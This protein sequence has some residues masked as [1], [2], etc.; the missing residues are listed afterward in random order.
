M[1]RP[2][3]GVILMER[4]YIGKSFY[5]NVLKLESHFNGT[6]LYWRVILKERISV[7]H[8]FKKVII[9]I[10]K[11]NKFNTLNSN[12]FIAF[13]VFL[14]TICYLCRSMYNV[15]LTVLILHV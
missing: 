3:I 8:H 12:Y 1:E 2:Y 14:V 4:P 7:G 13:G 9:I 6:S 10:K 5:W 11:K 15:T